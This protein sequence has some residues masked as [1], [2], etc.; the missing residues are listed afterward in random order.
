[1]LRVGVVFDLWLFC[2][3]NT[4]FLKKELTLFTIWV[5]FRRLSD[6]RKWAQDLTLVSLSFLSFL[7]SLGLESERHLLLLE[8]FQKEAQIY[9]NNGG[10]L[11]PVQFANVHFHGNM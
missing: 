7:C 4:L 11:N 3:W 5:S 9:T 2:V 6:E 10:V 1:M 8:L